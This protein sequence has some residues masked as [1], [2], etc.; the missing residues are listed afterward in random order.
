MDK[1]LDRYVS[2][3]RLGKIKSPAEFDAVPSTGQ[4]ISNQIK[5]PPRYMFLLPIGI[6][7]VAFALLFFRADLRASL[8]SIFLL[9]TLLLGLIFGAVMFYAG[10]KSILKEYTLLVVSIDVVLLFV[11]FILT[12]SIIFSIFCVVRGIISYGIWSGH[13]ALDDSDDVSL[14]GLSMAVLTPLLLFF[15]ILY[16]IAR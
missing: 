6:F 4:E 5:E 12:G 8:N 1:F 15:T 9:L 16:W 3:E 2:E 13:K 10:L 11:G 14:L 7:V